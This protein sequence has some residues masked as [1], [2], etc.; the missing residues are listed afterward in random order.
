M[1]LYIVIRI[2]I[3]LFFCLLVYSI[4][5]T[6][7]TP[8]FEGNVSSLVLNDKYGYYSNNLQEY[9]YHRYFSLWDNKRV[10]A[11]ID[12]VIILFLFIFVSMLS[13]LHY[14]IINYLGLNFEG[15]IKF[16]EIKRNIS[17]RFGDEFHEIE[18]KNKK[19]IYLDENISRKKIKFKEIKFDKL[20][21]DNYYLKLSNKGLIDQLGFSE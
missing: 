4:V 12:S 8:E 3:C 11:I 9:N 13:G 19:D 14:V 15:N 20:G 16:D 5:V 7:S 21:K 18:I 2:F 17:I 1:I 6:S 10:Y